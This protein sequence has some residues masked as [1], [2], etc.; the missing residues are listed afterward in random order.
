MQEA[1]AALDSIRGSDTAGRVQHA[2]AYLDLAQ[3]HFE[4]V[5]YSGYVIATQA[6]V[7]AQQ[8]AAGT[9]VTPPAAMAAIGSKTL[10][11]PITRAAR[12]T[13]RRLWQ[14][15]PLLAILLGW[16]VAGILAGIA[17]LPFQQGAIAG[18]RQTLFPIW[19]LGLL[20]MV[21]LGVVRSIW[22]IGRRRN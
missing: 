18:L 4:S 19:A 21:L 12:H 14:T 20:G 3:A 2:Q 6:A 8:T 11:R 10:L 17:S 5:S 16:L 9:K 13:A 1:G 7:L 22:R 15:L